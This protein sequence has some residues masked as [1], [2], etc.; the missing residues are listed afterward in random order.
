MGALAPTAPAGSG[1]LLAGLALGR[2]AGESAI[3]CFI[4][5]LAMVPVLKRVGGRHAAALGAAV[6]VPMLVK[7]LTGNAPV[8]EKSRGPRLRAYAARL[9]LD[10]DTRAT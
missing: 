5:D 10:R 8:A 3:G 1:L 6:V 9:L 7:R 2:A 4:A